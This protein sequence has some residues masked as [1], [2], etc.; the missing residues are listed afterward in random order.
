[1]LSVFCRR[2]GDSRDSLA[3]VNMHTRLGFNWNDDGVEACDSP[4]LA[5]SCR[6]WSSRKLAV[7]Q[8]RPFSIIWNGSNL[9]RLWGIGQ[10]Q[11]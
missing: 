4:R 11:R 2:H 8:I 9:H 6:G 1:M 10:D 5:L 7:V 3:F